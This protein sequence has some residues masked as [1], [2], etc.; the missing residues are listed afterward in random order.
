MEYLGFNSV[1][2]I[3]LDFLFGGNILYVGKF[4]FLIFEFSLLF[5]DR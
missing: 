3:V 4:N 5:F 2:D 1:R